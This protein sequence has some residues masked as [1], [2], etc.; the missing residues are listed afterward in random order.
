MKIVYLLIGA[1]CLAGCSSPETP[2]VEANQKRIE[3]VIERI[4]ETVVDAERAGEMRQIVT[5]LDSQLQTHEASL[6]AK[7]DAIIKANADY[8][9]TRQ[10]L[11]ALYAE[12]SSETREMMGQIKNAHFAMKELSSPEEWKAISGGRKQLIEFN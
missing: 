9:T 10:E 12:A 4:D 3:D 2:Q 8:A 11:E 7:R 6:N 1:A 5:Q